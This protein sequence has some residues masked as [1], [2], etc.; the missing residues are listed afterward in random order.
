MAKVNKKNIIE[1]PTDLLP[2]DGDELKTIFSRSEKESLL[3]NYETAE[4]QIEA[5]QAQLEDAKKFK[6]DCAFELQKAFGTKKFNYKG[7]ICQVTS[8]T[9]KAG[10]E[11]PVYF[12]KRFSIEVSE[13]FS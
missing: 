8:H 6:S 9:K 1:T 10:D 7:A 5:L 12:L 13:S 4:S 11:A 2:P 3:R